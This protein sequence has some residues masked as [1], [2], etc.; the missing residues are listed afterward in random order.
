MEDV[1]AEDDATVLIQGEYYMIEE[2]KMQSDEA[3]NRDRGEIQTSFE[4]RENA[5]FVQKT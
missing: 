5:C 2:Y 4:N 3:D 1:R